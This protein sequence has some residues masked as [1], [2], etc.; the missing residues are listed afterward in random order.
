MLRLLYSVICL[1]YTV[2][3]QT[4]CLGDVNSDSIVDVNDLLNVL[5]RF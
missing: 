2:K 4:T 3:S 1:F 5:S